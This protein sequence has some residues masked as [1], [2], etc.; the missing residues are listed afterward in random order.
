[1]K[2]MTRIGFVGECIKKF[3]GGISLLDVTVGKKYFCVFS[4]NLLYV[5]VD[6]ET[7]MA[8]AVRMDQVTRLFNIREMKS[9]S[10]MGE[11][12]LRG[13]AWNVLSMQRFE[14]ECLASYLFK[15]KELAAEYRGNINNSEFTRL[16]DAYISKISNIA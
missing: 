2:N 7:T 16:T 11:K 1:M 14:E 13:Y 5:F 3:D 6:K 8:Y 10:T 15:L 12:Q 4:N 9:I